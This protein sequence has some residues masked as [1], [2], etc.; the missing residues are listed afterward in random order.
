MR[1]T[2]L[3]TLIL[4]MMLVFLISCG[5]GNK[6]KTELVRPSI[7]PAPVVAKKPPLK[8]VPKIKKI[9][10]TDDSTGLMWQDDGSDKQRDWYGAVKYCENLGLSGFSDWR[11]PMREELVNIFAKKEKFQTLKHSNFWSSS[12]CVIN[13]THAWFVSFGEGVMPSEY[14]SYI[15]RKHTVRC[16]RIGK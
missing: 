9:V 13:D 3:S 12:K 6:K 2:L 1:K 7:V 14:D 16:V 4:F 10:M 8:S 15:G 5:D 11:L